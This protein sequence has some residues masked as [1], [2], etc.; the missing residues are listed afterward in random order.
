M[1]ER[2]TQE[3]MEIIAWGKKKKIQKQ[4]NKDKNLDTEYQSWDINLVPEF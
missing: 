2:N 4:S 3:F 1:Q